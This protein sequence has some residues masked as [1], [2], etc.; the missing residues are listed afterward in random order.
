MKYPFHTQ[1]MPVVGYEAQRLV[2][3]IDQGGYVTNDIAIATAKRIA[4]RRKA[5][6]GDDSTAHELVDATRR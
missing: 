1:S 5:R 2:S 4:E 6:E 3:A